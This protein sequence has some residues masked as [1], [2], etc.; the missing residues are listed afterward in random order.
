MNE[1]ESKPSKW[2]QRVSM[3][4]CIVAGVA[5]VAWVIGVNVAQ[6]GTIRDLRATNAEQDLAYQE[7]V[8]NGQRLYE[9]LLAAG[10]DP[11]GEN[12]EEVADTPGIPG[13]RGP[14]GFDG[15][16]GEDGE[17]GAPGPTGLPGAPGE[18]GAD[19]QPG[20][21][22]S[23]G[24][25]G[26]PGPAGP[27]G[28]TGATGPAGPAGPAGPTCPT[29]YEVTYVWLLVQAEENGPPSREQAAI[30]QP[31]ETQEVTP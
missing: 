6:A 27:R 30:C 7:Q 29:G 12:P 22:G 19:G 24:T 14:R 2:L 11:E 25:D 20:E 8:E 1:I 3:A 17:P 18:P 16:D 23:D 31:V 10:E 28:E 5:L 4:A 15:Q 26:A 13:E 21:D 9:Q